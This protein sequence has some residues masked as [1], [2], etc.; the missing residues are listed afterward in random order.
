MARKPYFANPEV[1]SKAAA[2]YKDGF[3]IYMYDGRLKKELKR[4]DPF[5]DEV[6]M[7][8][9]EAYWKRKPGAQK[10]YPYFIKTF[11]MV[12]AQWYANK[13]QANKPDPRGPAAQ[14]IKDIM[15]GMF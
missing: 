14:S 7:L 11:Q 15:K 13:Q 9:F 5:P 12:S 3:N 10:P 4:S 6:M 2:V 8:L 1:E